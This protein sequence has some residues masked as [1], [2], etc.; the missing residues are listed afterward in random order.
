MK[1]LVLGGTRFLGRHVVA[2]ALARGDQVT[3]FHRGRTEP[4]LFPECEHVLGDREADLARLDGRSWDAVV[5][6]CGFVPRVVEL[7]VRSLGPRIG[8]YV[9]VSSISVYANPVAPGA[10]ETAPLATLEDPAT[11]EVTG[12]TYGGLKAACERAAEAALPGRVTSVRAGLLVGPWDYTDRFPYWVRR[13]VEGGDVLVPDAAS[14]PLQVID[15]RD[16]A[17]WILEAIERRATGPY[18]LT[19]PAEPL[20]FGGCLDAIQRAL[21]SSAR[22]IPVPEAF[23]AEQK[24]TPWSEMPLWAPEVDGFL[25]VSLARA[26]AAGLTF[27]PLEATVRD[28]WDWIRQTGG[29]FGTQAST[30]LASPPPSSLAREREQ[31]LLAAW[32][33]RGISAPPA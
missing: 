17:A 4:A 22:R 13:L 26:L 19:G 28:T 6:T 1:V 29:P 18:N 14:Q 15:A 8:Q 31:D 11:E 9:F 21:A 20:T 25:S 3:I 33:A 23:L 2:A 24:V 32:S 12:A 27:R 30:I 10:D 7:A 16:A 5:D